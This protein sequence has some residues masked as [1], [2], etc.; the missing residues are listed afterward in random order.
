MP[1]LR[2]FRGDTLLVELDLSGERLDVGDRPGDGVRLD[3]LGLLGSPPA[4]VAP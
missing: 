3:E 4:P 2:V 1:T